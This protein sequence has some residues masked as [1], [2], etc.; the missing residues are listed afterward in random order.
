MYVD[1]ARWVRHGRKSLYGILMFT[2]HVLVKIPCPFQFH[3]GR[4]DVDARF[5]RIQE[6]NTY[7]TDITGRQTLSL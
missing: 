1:T 2:Q 7:C 3:V 5:R 4:W 6:E